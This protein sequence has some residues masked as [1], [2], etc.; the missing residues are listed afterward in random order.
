MSGMAETV[1]DIQ[2]TEIRA[3]KWTDASIEFAGV[4]V[5]V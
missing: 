3:R 1:C 5:D 4:L 2:F